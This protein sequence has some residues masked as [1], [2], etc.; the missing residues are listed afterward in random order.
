MGKINFKSKVNTY[1]DF[2][3]KGILF[4]DISPILEDYLAFSSLIDNMARS[5]TFKMA[6]AIII[7]DARGFIL[8]SSISIKTGKPIVMARKYGKLPGE[9]ICKSYKLEYG[10]NKLCIQRES[11]K[12]FQNFVIVDD[13]LAT[14][15]TV[16]CIAKI[17]D[18]ERKKI[19]GLSVAIELKDL[20]G[21]AKFSFPVTSEMVY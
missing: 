4:R 2:P 1:K 11:I 13:I 15:G 17:L 8:G 6:D 10:E 7:V 20:N 19:L 21:R 5:K 14:G 18:S 16:D 3:E 12:H 9:I